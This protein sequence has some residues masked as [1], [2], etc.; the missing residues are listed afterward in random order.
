MTKKDKIVMIEKK[1][2]EKAVKEENSR[3]LHLSQKEVNL[4]PSREKR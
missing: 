2:A 4:L 3:K 1:L